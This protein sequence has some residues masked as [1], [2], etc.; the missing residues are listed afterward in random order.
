MALDFCLGPIPGDSSS[1]WRWWMA[2]WG[3]NGEW[4]ENKMIDAWMDGS[5]TLYIAF[6]HSLS[7]SLCPTMLC[8]CS[9]N[10]A[11]KP[12]ALF[13]RGQIQGRGR[14][15]HPHHHHH[16]HHHHYPHTPSSLQTKPCIC[17]AHAWLLACDETKRR[18]ES[19]QCQASHEIV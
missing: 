17:F 19:C 11:W 5:S 2:G 3:I 18:R 10:E 6:E 1:Q 7:L 12:E 14:R 9:W 13:N 8:C 16:H 15:S 4:I